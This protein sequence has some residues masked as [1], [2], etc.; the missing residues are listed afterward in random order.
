MERTVAMIFALRALFAPSSP[1]IVV[2]NLATPQPEIAYA[3]HNSD[4]PL[5]MPGSGARR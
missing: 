4:R 1:A 5:M 2:P 3:I